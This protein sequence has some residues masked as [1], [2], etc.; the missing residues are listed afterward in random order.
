MTAP[1]AAPVNV[2]VGAGRAVH[3]TADGYR[4]TLCG[5]EGRTPGASRLRTTDADVTCKRCAAII[6]T[7]EQRAE[8]ERQVAETVAA[9][10]AG[11][12]RAARAE[13]NRAPVVMYRKVGTALYEVVR[14]GQA[15]GRV[16]RTTPAHA[17]FTARWASY[18]TTGE[19]L[20]SGHASRDAARD[21][22]LAAVEP[23]PVVTVEQLVAD[24]L[25]LGYRTVR[26]YV[27]APGREVGQVTPWTLDR[28][29][30]AFAREV[31]SRARPVL[32][33]GTPHEHGFVVGEELRVDPR[34]D[35]GQALDAGS[36]RP[37]LGRD[38]HGWYRFG[39]PG[40]RADQPATDG[41]VHLMSDDLLDACGTAPDGRLVVVPDTTPERITCPACRRLV[42]EADVPPSA[43]EEERAT[44]RIRAA[45]LRPGDLVVDS[46]GERQYAAFDVADAS[47]GQAV[48]VVNVWTAIA[49][50]ERGLPPVLTVPS[51]R[52]LLVSRTVPAGSWDALIGGRA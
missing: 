38:D 50:Q 8:T 25:H 32:V 47:A 7:D 48:S 3:R 23:A 17:S 19:R 12:A 6:A 14:D 37:Y 20:T 51:A 41:L 45:E 2:T 42:T 18:S 1:T 33:D 11:I 30:R 39:V 5:A 34:Y 46:L 44:V 10:N 22:L 31:E 40:A 26:E 24:T 35:L 49:D 9:S 28:A 27:E 15:I 52:E 29:E 13:A 21:A 16:A 36:E 43:P 4:Y